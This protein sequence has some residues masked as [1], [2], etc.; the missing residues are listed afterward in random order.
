MKKHFCSLLWG[1]FLEELH[2]IHTI[3]LNI[4][5][6]EHDFVLNSNHSCSL[7]SPEPRCTGLVGPQVRVS[8]VEINRLYD[9]CISW[10]V[11]SLDL[12][13][14]VR[15]LERRRNVFNIWQ[16]LKLQYTR[17]HHGWP[18]MFYCEGSLGNFTRCWWDLHY[19]KMLPR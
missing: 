12:A 17:N 15:T 5:V 14:S 7:T 9:V 8:A 11:V 4:I 6:T 1:I 2:S 16:N 19:R 3:M 18:T 10:K 13:V